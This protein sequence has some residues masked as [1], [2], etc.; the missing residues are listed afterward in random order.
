MNEKL[1]KKMS[2]VK[3]HFVK[4]KQ[5]YLGITIGAGL[6]MLAGITYV[7]VR[8]TSQLD[9][10]G[11]SVL[12]Q[13]GI[14]VLDVKAENSQV[15]TNYGSMGNVSY[16]SA[17]RQGPPSWVIRHV[18]TGEIYTSQNSAATNLDI[19]GSEL[20]KHLNGLMDNVRGM[21]FERICMAA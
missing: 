10:R 15:V 5:L 17:N 2:R 19:S 14:S 18:E 3:T 7:I 21:T 20:S 8:D 4:H 1:P 6:I 12:P 16:I 9:Q 13:R 11:N